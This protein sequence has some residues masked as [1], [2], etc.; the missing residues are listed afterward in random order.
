MTKNS[1]EEKEQGTEK[2]YV[3][4]VELTLMRRQV[5]FKHETHLPEQFIAWRIS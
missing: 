2:L 4:V 1:R 3:I 5:S